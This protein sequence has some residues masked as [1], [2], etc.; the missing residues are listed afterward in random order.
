MELEKEIERLIE[1]ALAEDIG[2][3]DITTE[4]CI[5]EEISTSAKFVIKQACVLAGL[6]FLETLFKKIDPKIEVTLLANEGSFQ[7]AGT[8][9]AKITGP[10][11]G[12]LSGERVALN[13]LQHASGVATAT[14]S[15]VKKVAGLDCAILDTRKTLP[16]LRALE[17]YAVKVGGGRNHRFGLDDRFIIKV[18]H[19]SFIPAHSSHPISHAISLAKS[20]SPHLPIEVEIENSAHLNEALKHDISAII[21]INMTPEEIKKCA[22]KIKKTEKKVYIESSGAITLDTIR[23]YAE[24]GVHGISL[25]AITHSVPAADIGMRLN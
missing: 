20:K 12:I 13:F 4:I 11:R 3:G 2:S 24:T 18:N 7:K 17:K 6:P 10:T 19:L 14:A 9:I 16:G 21:L 15:Y 8:I 22:Q 25:G 5:P 23:A 1:I